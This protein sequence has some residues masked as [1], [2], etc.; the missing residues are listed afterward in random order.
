MPWRTPRPYGAARRPAR[1]AWC[2]RSF[3]HCQLGTAVAHQR[4]AIGA[5]A[6]VCTSGPAQAAQRAG[7][8]QSLAGQRL[9]VAAARHLHQHGTLGRA[10]RAEHF[11]REP[12]RRRSCRRPIG[13]LEARPRRTSR[14]LLGDQ[15]DA[16]AALDQRL[17]LGRTRIAADQQGRLGCRCAQQEHLA[18][19][20]V[21]RAW[22]GVEI[23]AVV[24]HRH[25]SEIVYGRKRRRPRAEHDLHLPS[26]DREERGVARCRRRCG[27]QHDVMT[28]TQHLGECCIPARD[29]SYVGHADDRASSAVQAPPAPPGRPHRAGS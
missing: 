22:L 24:P 20:R 8:R 1:G 2:R 17:S 10:H 16:P 13:D 9:A 14:C 26:R 5:D 4:Q 12:S 27:R 25:E 11:L 15:L 3:S 6:D 23:V 21:G 28:R 19:M 18:G 7:W 29:V